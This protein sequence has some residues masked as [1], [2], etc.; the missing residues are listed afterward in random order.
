[1]GSPERRSRERTEIRQRILDVAREMFVEHGYEATTMRAIAEQI[2]YTPTAIYHHFRNK[3]ALLTELCVL[4]FQS[5]AGAFQRI[6]R[7]E[8]PIERLK[9]TGEAYVEFALAHPMQYQLMFMTMRP[10]VTGFEKGQGTPTEDAY[11]FLRETC[12][13][14]IASRKLR[15]EFQD[16]EELAQ[17]AWSSLH[18]LMALHIVHRE[19]HTMVN[20]RDP[21][22][23]A[24]RMADA[25]IRGMLRSTRG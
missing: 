20:W 1:M 6:G 11:A 24:S 7:I 12:Q 2:E 4:D 15:P 14:V 3:E 13:A 8:D 18:G 23:T 21:R 25:L 9:R 17:I 22:A 5:L 19:Q 10:A 16:P